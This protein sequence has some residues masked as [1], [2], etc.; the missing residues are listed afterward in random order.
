MEK[1]LIDVHTHI[2]A[3]REIKAQSAW[4]EITLERLLGYMD[5]ETI[6]KAVVLP[7]ESK[8]AFPQMPTDYVLDACGK[9]PD[10]LIPFCC[11]DP[12]DTDPHPKIR[13]YVDLGCNG[14]GEHKVKLRVDDPRSKE[15][16]RLCGKLEIPLLIHIDSV[17]NVDMKAYEKVVKD[18]SSTVFIAHGP[19]WW[20]E[21]SGKVDPAVGYPKGKVE[22]EGRVDSILQ[23]HP[24]A[25]ADL[26]AGSGFNALQRDL[27][28]AKK[29]VA[30]NYRK[31]LFGTD[32]LRHFDKGHSHTELLRSLNLSEVA[33][34]AITHKNAEALLKLK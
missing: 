3:Y 12:R 13:R 26:S 10:R 33:Y 2:G 34:Q 25:Y 14:F 19:G 8:D 9:I 21:I 15:I 5:S 27:P 1:L 29:F 11:V 7:I 31:L 16:Y 6:G 23:D 32:L 28:F 4:G 22:P 20:R 17:Y 18:F 30:R 24:N